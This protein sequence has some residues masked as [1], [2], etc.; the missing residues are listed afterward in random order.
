MHPKTAARV[1]VGVQITALRVRQP[2]E[3][4]P[5]PYSASAGKIIGLSGRSILRISGRLY[6]HWGLPLR[7]IGL[8]L[9]RLYHHC[10]VRVPLRKVWANAYP[11]PEPEPNP[12]PNSDPD[13]NPYLESS[14]KGVANPNLNPNLNP[15]PN[16]NLDTSP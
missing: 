4:L 8:P 12:Y 10:L 9:E 1:A 13:P 16:L 14:S 15:N 11:N 5:A 6:H 7:V 2:K 3:V